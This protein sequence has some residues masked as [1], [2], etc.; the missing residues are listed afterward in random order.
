MPH[1][2]IEY[3]SSFGSK[4]DVQQL[5]G[6]VHQAAEG[7]GLFDSAAIKSRAIGYQ[8]FQVGGAQQDFIHVTA[9]ILP[10]R[11]AEQKANLSRL[12]LQQLASFELTR[13][14]L[15]VEVVDIDQGSYAKQLA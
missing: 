15:T 10:G 11:T 14:S 13:V 2:I 9:K 1:C 3:S 4:L 8:H 5:V 12:I 6:K 7:S